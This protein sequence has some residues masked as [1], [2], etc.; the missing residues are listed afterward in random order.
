MG[1]LKQ[2]KVGQRRSAL[3]RVSMGVACAAFSAFMVAFSAC[4]GGSATSQVQPPVYPES[5]YIYGSTLTGGQAKTCCE[6]GNPKSPLPDG[7]PRPAGVTPT[8]ATM[9]AFNGA[10]GTARTSL[11]TANG[12]VGTGTV[13]KNNLSAAT[14]GE[15]PAS[16]DGKKDGIGGAGI[17]DLF[18]G[19]DNDSAQNGGGGGAGA[20]GGGGSG[21]G[22]GFGAGVKTDP[23]PDNSAKTAAAGSAEDGSSVMS[24][25]GGGRAGGRGGNSGFDNL[26]GAGGQNAATSGMVDMSGRGPAGV[27]TSGSA[28]PDDY[29][30][31]LKRAESIFKVVERR[32]TEKARGWATRDA[33]DITAKAR[34]LVK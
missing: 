10:V 7:C 11:A 16:D 20:G 18:K 34:M 3:R 24:G 30:S 9:A 29:F 22:S 13:A 31:L 1:Q 21:L 25:S 14:A 23:S 8:T 27:A 32:Y 17:G 6:Q 19:S 26:F 33:T 12:L 5:C 15:I 2:S 28:D 4:K